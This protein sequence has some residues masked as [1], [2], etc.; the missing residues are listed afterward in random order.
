MGPMRTVHPIARPFA[1]LFL[2][3]AFLAAA[4]EAMSHADGAIQG[5]FVP[6]H[7]VLVVVAPDVL[8]RLQVGLTQSLGPWAWDPVLLRLLALPG[9][10]LFGLPA[11]FL[12][13]LGRKTPGMDGDDEFGDDP[14]T[15]FEELTRAA[16]ADG[17]TETDADLVSSPMHADDITPFNDPDNP[18]DEEGQ[19]YDPAPPLAENADQDPES[20]NRR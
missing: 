15:L 14:H 7:D 11:G 12:I 19:P 9:W 1:W 6:A 2:L 8:I 3:L 18:S 16:R 13:W 20:P 4:A 5:I 10:L 17:Y